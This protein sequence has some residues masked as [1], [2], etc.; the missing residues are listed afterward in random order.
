MQI[1]DLAQVTG[2]RLLAK[3]RN[4]LRRDYGFPKASNTK[5]PA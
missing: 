5:N 2:D 4:Q 3:V 1:A